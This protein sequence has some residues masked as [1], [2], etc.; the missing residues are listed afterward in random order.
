[1]GKL[2]SSC[3]RRPFRT[4]REICRRRNA[5]RDGRQRDAVWVK[6]ADWTK[7][8]QELSDAALKAVNASK[9]KNFDALVQA[10]GQIVSSCESRHKQFKPDLPTE[11]IVHT[12]AH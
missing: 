3:L 12:H 6:S 11:G 4:P 9:A 10:N 5:G 7:H 1:M 8:A 2:K